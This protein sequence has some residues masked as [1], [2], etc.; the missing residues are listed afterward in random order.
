[1]PVGSLILPFRARKDRRL[2]T[3]NQKMPY[4]L[5]SFCGV[6][7]M[8]VIDRKGVIRSA[9]LRHSIYVCTPIYAWTTLS[10]AYMGSKKKNTRMKRVD[11]NAPKIIHPINPMVPS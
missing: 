10:K 8:H 11:V 4:G 1:V 9:T 6:P 3:P 7:R 5:P 2:V